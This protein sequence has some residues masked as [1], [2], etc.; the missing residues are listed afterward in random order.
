LK[1]LFIVAASLQAFLRSSQNRLSDDE[2][3]GAFSVGTRNTLSTFNEDDATGKGIG[4][5]FRIRLGYKLNSEWYL[6][7]ITSQ[8]GSL[9]YRNDYH[10]GW[11]LMFYMGNNYSG[12]RLGG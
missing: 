2:P 4:G 1:H 11:S 8:N 9:S 12:D 7:Y 10:I 3:A 6:D 5:Q